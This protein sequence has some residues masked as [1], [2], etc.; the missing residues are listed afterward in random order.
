MI[1]ITTIAPVKFQFTHPRGV[2]LTGEAGEVAD[3]VFQFTHPRGVRR[4]GGQRV[5]RAGGFNSRTRE[6]CD[7]KSPPKWQ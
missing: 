1:D 5:D 3:K 4:N 2:R 6:G 7:S